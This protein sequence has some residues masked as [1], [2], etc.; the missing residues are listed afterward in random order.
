MYGGVVPPICGLRCGT[1]LAVTIR[2]CA[3]RAMSKRGAMSTPRIG[4]FA[5]VRNRRGL[6]TGVEP[7]DGPTGRLHLVS[8][9]YS[10]S[11]S[12]RSAWPAVAVSARA[13]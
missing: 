12:A 6:T 2:E 3:R 13:V 5:T 7:F 1:R 11:I 4:M 9:D 10:G 8:I